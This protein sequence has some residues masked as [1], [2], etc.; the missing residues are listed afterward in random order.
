MGKIQMSDEQVQNNDWELE[1]VQGGFG[2]E[3][4]CTVERNGVQV[5]PEGVHV[6]F[7][8]IPKHDVPVLTGM[9]VCYGPDGIE[10]WRDTVEFKL[11]MNS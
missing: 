8:D 11:G 10:K 1:V 7:Q 9:V 5:V 4:S 6:E 2:A 3:A